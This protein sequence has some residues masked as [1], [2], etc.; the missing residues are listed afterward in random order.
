[1]K[2]LAEL[3]AAQPFFRGVSAGYLPLLVQSG[4]V[5]QVPAHKVLFEKGSEA[6]Q[7]YLI[8]RGEIALETQF[9]P[10]IGSAGVQ[11]LHDGEAMGW[12]WFFSPRVWQFTA[13]AK[14]DAEVILFDGWKLRQAADADHSF[15]YDLAKR[16]GEMLGQRL[17]Y[18]RER[19]LQAYRV[20]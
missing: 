3:I 5:L 17:E 12:S 16:V 18:A 9:S 19:L 1:M 2:T 7:F 8:V 20:G 11:V 13:T 10:G 14:T 4:R 6:E 15:G